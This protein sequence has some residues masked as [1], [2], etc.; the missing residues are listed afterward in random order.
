M[1]IN[2]RE[3][4]MLRR[5]QRKFSKVSFIVIK[6]SAKGEK[7]G[8]S[9]PCGMCVRAMKILCI[10]NVYYTNVDGDIIMEKINTMVSNHKSQ[11]ERNL[12]S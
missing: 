3:Q 11:M 12:I 4:K 2:D 5:I 1:N 9:R 7:L 6:Q 10:K 8:S